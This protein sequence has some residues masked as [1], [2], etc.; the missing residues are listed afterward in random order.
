MN[1]LTPNAPVGRLQFVIKTYWKKYPQAV[2]DTAT[3][4]SF[5]I[6]RDQ[7]APM[8]MSD[9]G[10]RRD[11]EPNF[12]HDGRVSDVRAVSR[13]RQVIGH[14]MHTDGSQIM[15]ALE[16]ADLLP[17]LAPLLSAGAEDWDYADAEDAIVLNLEGRREWELLRLIDFIAP[18]T[19]P[20]EADS[21]IPWVARELVALWKASAGGDY[22]RAVTILTEK[23]P[24]IAQW[25]KET[26][27]D[28]NKVD[29]AQALATVAKYRFKTARVPQGV[30]AYTFSDGWTVQDLRAKRE[31]EAE[32]KNL[33]HCGA[34]YFQAVRD[35]E[36]RIYSLRDPEGQPWITMEWTPIQ[37]EIDEIPHDPRFASQASEGHAGWDAYVAMNAEAFNDPDPDSLAARFRRSGEF[38]QIKGKLNCDL[39]GDACQEW[40]DQVW[41]DAVASAP[42]DEPPPPRL[43]VSDLRAKVVKFIHALFHGDAYGLLM[44]GVKA[45]DINWSGVAIHEQSGPDD[46]SGADLRRAHIEPGTVFGEISGADFDGQDLH[47]CVV[48]TRATERAARKVSFRG[49]NLRD[50]DFAHADVSG[51]DF[52]GADLSGA[53]FRSAYMDSAILK[54]IT[55][56]RSTDFVN[57]EGVDVS[58]DQLRTWGNVDDL[59]LYSIFGKEPRTELLR[60]C[61]DFFLDREDGQWKSVGEAEEEAED[62]ERFVLGEDEDEDEED[63]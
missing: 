19:E 50:T 7:V 59:P 17:G 34:G 54:G 11:W 63:E 43:R 27:T 37:G 14:I 31:L 39:D 6:G 21:I 28:I 46:L 1:G 8:L 61:G 42:E 52:T 49:A 12:G 10:W 56:S 36:S 23:A 16:K 60:G 22:T 25:A 20:N 30:A 41:R 5:L 53:S 32:G 15:K 9:D 40:L 47:D 51:S 24:A 57:A 2:T 29:L 13:R 33:V 45:E 4:A 55:I 3:V 35:G 18:M 62:Y 48:Q 58:H 38:N 44:A 26:R